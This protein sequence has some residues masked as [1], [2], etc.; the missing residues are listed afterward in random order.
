MINFGGFAPSYPL[1]L[2]PLLSSFDYRKPILKVDS[3]EIIASFSFE[4]ASLSKSIET[5][6]FK[7]SFLLY[8]AYKS[9]P[10]K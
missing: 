3:F 5:M 6:S 10:A 1:M 9:A 8:T 7:P 4:I 2:I